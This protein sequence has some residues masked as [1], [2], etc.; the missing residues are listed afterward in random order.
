[1]FFVLFRVAA[2]TN[3]GPPFSWR[4]FHRSFATF[5]QFLLGFCVNFFS[6]STRSPLP[7]LCGSFGPAPPP[8]RQAAWPIL[9]PPPPP[10][11]VPGCPFVNPNELVSA[12]GALP[13]FPPCPVEGGG[14]QPLLVFSFFFLPLGLTRL[15]PPPGVGFR[16]FPPILG[17]MVFQ[18]PLGRGHFCCRSTPP[19]F[20]FLSPVFSYFVAFLFSFP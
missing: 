8:L 12:L 14:T 16:F 10:I 1:M 5:L 11:L 3:Q 17:C 13:S 18:W 6:F 9:L 19:T 4:S 7:G 15:S 20:R 2:I